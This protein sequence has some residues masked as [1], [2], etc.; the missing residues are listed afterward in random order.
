M[1]AA[2]NTRLPSASSVSVTIWVVNVF[3]ARTDQLLVEYPAATPD[4]DAVR[5]EWNLPPATAI[6]ALR[7]TDERLPFV[8]T[9]LDVPLALA[10]AQEAF[11]E[12][13]A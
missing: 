8:N 4:R 1:R 11:L 5:K 9:L 13:Y 10:E 12:Q 3:D 2:R 6:G 7:I